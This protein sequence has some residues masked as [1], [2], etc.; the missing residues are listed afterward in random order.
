MDFDTAFT[1]LLGNEGG[2]TVDSGGPTNWGISQHAY[3]ELSAEDIKN[4]T[5]EQAKAYYRRDYWA[6]A[7]CESVPDLIKFELFDM[8]VNTSARGHPVTAIKALQ[9]AAGVVDDG[10]I[11]VAS[12]QAMN[13]MNPW[14]LLVRFYSQ[15]ITYYT[16]LNRAQW[17]ESGAGW[18]NR[19]AANQMHV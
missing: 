11:G 15:R 4:L 3:P 5:K 1:Q 19:I 6:P 16:H 9:R 14:R 2:Y 10:Q 13:S 17:L 12:L 7:G 18:M 8:A